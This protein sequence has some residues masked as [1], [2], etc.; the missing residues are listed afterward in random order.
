MKRILALFL[1]AALALSAVGCSSAKTSSTASSS[2]ASSQQA[3][4]SASTAPSSASS[5][6]TLKVDKGLFDVTVTIPAS[7][8]KGVDIDKAI[9]GAKK[10]GVGDAVK[11]K[12]G[13]VTYKMSKGTHE[14]MMAEIKQNEFDS[15]KQMKSGKDYKSIKDITYN[16]DFSEMNMVVDKATF[17]KSL[18]GMAALGLYILGGY[19]QAFNGTKTGDIKVKINIIDQKTNKSYKTIVYPDALN[20]TSSK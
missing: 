10:A 12:D 11:N 6:Q 8:Y 3:S 5:A 14:K 9:A 19:Y 15:I 4:S 1:C 7:F 16:D 17:D 2:A 13:S 18:D 20:Q